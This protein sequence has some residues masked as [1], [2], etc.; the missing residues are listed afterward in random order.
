MM[1]LVVRCDDILNLSAAPAVFS[2]AN[3]VSVEYL[4]VCVRV[5]V[6]ARPLIGRR[7]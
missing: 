6:E 1:H 7:R 3:D 2:W 5:C 4:N